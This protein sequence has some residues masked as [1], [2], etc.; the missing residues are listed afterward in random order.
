MIG[1]LLIS[2]SIYIS[3]S[4][5]CIS[6][7]YIDLIN[8]RYSVSPDAGILRRNNISNQIQYINGNIHVPLVLK[9]NKN[10]ILDVNPFVENWKVRVDPLF[11]GDS[12]YSGFGLPVTFINPVSK[13]ISMT[14]SFIP[15]WN[16]KKLNLSSESFQ[17]GGAVL[18]VINQ[19][20]NIKYKFGIYCNDEFFGLFIIPLAGIDWKISERSKIFGILPGNLVWEIKGDNHFY[21]GLSFR[22]TTNSYLKGVVQKQFIRI[23]DNQLNAFCDFYLTKHLVLNAEAGHSIFRRIRMGGTGGTKKYSF[24]EK[25][26]DNLLF[27]IALAWRMRFDTRTESILQN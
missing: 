15:R 25:I 19:N 21:Y 3:L 26:N 24:S 4:Q 5:L 23:D 27:K 11:A 7:P 1:K 10:R 8:F 2:S 22:A 17:V 16:A 20:E 13:K 6:Q 9:K 18:I 14:I 12:C